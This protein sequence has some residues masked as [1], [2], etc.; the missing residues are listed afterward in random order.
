MQNPFPQMQGSRVDFGELSQAFAIFE[1]SP[2]G[3]KL[4][5]IHPNPDPLGFL[6]VVSVDPEDLV[7]SDIRRLEELGWSASASH[8]RSFE[9]LYTAV[10]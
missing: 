6:V 1:A 9:R 7:R 8:A 10:G 2:G 3:D 4:L 5:S